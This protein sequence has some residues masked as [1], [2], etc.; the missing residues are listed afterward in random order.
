MTA[1]PA[2]RRGWEAFARPAQINQ[3]RYEAVRAYVLEGAP[4][5]AAAA[6]FGYSPSA[7]ASLVRDFRAGKLELFAEPRRPGRKSAPKK[8]AARGRV[9]ELR[10]QGLSGYEISTRLAAEGRPLNRTGVGQILAEEGF[11][12]L[13]RHPEPEAS[14]SPAT[15]GRDTS[16]PRAKVIDFAAF[17]AAATTR[18]AGLLLAVPDLV[19]LDLPA[20]AR[21]AGYPGTRVV[22]AVCWLLSLLALKL[23]ATRRVS[24]VDDLLDDPAS[25]LFAGLAILPKKSA[26]TEY[27]YRLSHDHQRN[28]LAALDAKLIA[29]GLAGSDQGIFDL[30]FHAVMHWG[31]DPALEKHYVPTRSQRARSVLTFFAQDSGTHNLVYA[32]ADIS[33]ATQHREVIAFCDHWKAV[34]GK[35]PAM[36]IMDQKVTN[37][38]VLGELDAR[39]VKFLTLRMRSPA[40][41]RHI[42]A[43]K[44]ASFKTITLDRPGP[45]NKPKVHEDKA[46]K[47]TSYPGT[48]RQLVVT[49]LGRDAATV[50]ITNEHHLG[51]KKLIS[52]YARRMTIEQRLA[53]IIRSFCADALSSTVN[54]NVDLD[55][56][57]CVLAQAL[58]AA[59]RTR[60][61]A[62]YATA[63]PDT[64]QRR[65]LD[66]SGT[67][68]TTGDQVTVRIDRRAYSPVLRQA[69]LPTDTI[70]PWWGNRRLHF[71]FA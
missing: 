60:L 23:T 6:R 58:L 4:L 32:N 69:D 40:L 25:A 2:P 44:S 9:I 21:R 45:H 37:Q 5:A 67:I 20:L 12:R 16:L 48:V 19:A 53:E 41:V 31:T 15:A 30:D 70:V 38:A 56:M 33:K 61:G 36:L 29:A 54:L 27:S 46:V 59:F 57:L 26:L 22:P 62:G 43:L 51:L 3:R 68:T 18:L 42:N 47:L 66:S 63:T 71:E 8:D 11:G 52:Q 55:I 13:L 39:G 35:D 64:L 50:I 7:L 1:E 49:G 34:S 28:F 65:F 10:R 24:H 17:P 14:I